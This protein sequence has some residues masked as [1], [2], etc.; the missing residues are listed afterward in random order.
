MIPQDLVSS[1]ALLFGL[2]MVALEEQH[3]SKPDSGDAH[4]LV[5]RGESFAIAPQGITESLLCPRVLLALHPYASQ[6]GQRNTY[7][8]MLVVICRPIDLRCPAQFC[9]RFIE[10]PLLCLDLP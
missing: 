7:V 8:V 1:P 10:P 9:F 2:R 5:V 6:I 3:S 4:K